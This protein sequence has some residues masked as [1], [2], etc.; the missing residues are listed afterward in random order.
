[1]HDRGRLES[2]QELGTAQNTHV[3]RRPGS[4]CDS[5]LENSQAVMDV[6]QPGTAGKG[7]SILTA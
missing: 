3:H 7:K 1:M 6:K 4:R 5:G 2:D